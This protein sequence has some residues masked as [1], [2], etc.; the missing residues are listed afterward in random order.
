MRQKASM[1]RQARPL[2]RPWRSLARAGTGRRHQGRGPPCA[3]SRRAT[4]LLGAAARARGSPPDLEQFIECYRQIANTFTGGVEYRVGNC[5]SDTRNPD[6]ANPMGSKGSMLIRDVEKGNVNS[7]DVEMNRNMI[8]GE[9]CIDD[10]PLSLI[11]QCIFSKSHPDTHN[12]CTSQL[13][14][15]S[16]RIEDRPAVER[17]NPRGNRYLVSHIVDPHFA[18]LRTI[19]MHRV[20]HEFGRPWCINYYLKMALPRLLQ[21]GGVC[22]TLISFVC[23]KETTVASFNV[24]QCCSGKRRVVLHQA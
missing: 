20:F 2:E 22:F 24:L 4:D 8:L 10:T 5:G 16:F 17:A 15:G 14:P 9:R 18:E 19:S 6:F 3:L 1:R 13:T 21:E 11:E 7:G 23:A 12:D